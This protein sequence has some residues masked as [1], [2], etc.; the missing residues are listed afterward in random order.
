MQKQFWVTS[1]LTW[2][3]GGDQIAALLQDWAMMINWALSFPFAGFVMAVMKLWAIFFLFPWIVTDRVWVKS[4][5]ENWALSFFKTNWHCT[6]SLSSLVNLS[7]SELNSG[8]IKSFSSLILLISWCCLFSLLSFLPILQ[9]EMPPRNR[10]RYQP[11]ISDAFVDGEDA[12]EGFCI[13]AS[14]TIFHCTQTSP[15]STY[16][17]LLQI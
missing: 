5:D 4:C 3:W 6:S 13:K 8:A 1:F 15:K 14:P 16:L 7:S 10:H 17:L 2:G 12:S 9:V 11:V